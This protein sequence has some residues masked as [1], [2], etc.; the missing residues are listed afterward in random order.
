MVWASIF[1]R[2]APAVRTGL[3]NKSDFNVDW[4]LNSIFAW[5]LVICV[6]VMSSSHLELVNLLL[7]KSNHRVALHYLSTMLHNLKLVLCN[8]V[9][10]PSNYLI[11]PLNLSVS[12]AKTSLKSLGQVHHLIHVPL[13]KDLI[14]GQ[15]IHIPDHCLDSLLSYISN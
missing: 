13:L 14:V 8:G 5:A 4:A 7:K 2:P 6:L 9:I 3:A 15:G 12:Q 1:V 10:S 11:K